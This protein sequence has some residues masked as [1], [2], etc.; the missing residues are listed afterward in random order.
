[1]TKI[2]PFACG[3]VR[4]I[5]VQLSDQFRACAMFH[6]LVRYVRAWEAQSGSPQNPHDNRSLDASSGTEHHH[7]PTGPAPHVYA[8]C[9]M[10]TTNPV[11]DGRIVPNAKA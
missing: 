10:S 5:E 7:P 8:I 11:P 6:A 4:R 2:S 3:T 1:M 9:H